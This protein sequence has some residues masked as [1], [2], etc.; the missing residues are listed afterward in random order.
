MRHSKRTSGDQVVN[1]ALHAF[2]HSSGEESS[3][4]LAISPWAV[5]GVSSHLLP[6]LT[7]LYQGSAALR[8]VL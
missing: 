7:G 1:H 5:T 6:L 3:Q 4:D 8:V 2:T